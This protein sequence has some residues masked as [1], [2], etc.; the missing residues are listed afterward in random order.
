M[1]NNRKLTLKVD[2][3]AVAFISGWIVP[4][5]RTCATR[6]PSQRIV[7]P[8]TDQGS[9]PKDGATGFG[10]QLLGTPLP[11]IRDKVS[12][13]P[14]AHKW[15]VRLKNAKKKPSE[16]FAVDPALDAQ[17][18]EKERVAA[19]WRAVDAWNLFDGST[20]LRIKCWGRAFEQ[21]SD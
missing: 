1:N 21:K 19:Y 14:T 11:G 10:F 4:L 13:N 7:D 8:S 5:I 20:R 6:S 15:D 2:D 12:W 3:R 9:Q 17:S 18:Y 16:D